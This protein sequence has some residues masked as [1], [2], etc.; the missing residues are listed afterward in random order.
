M[1]KLI[2]NADDFG[3][4]PLFN[5]MILELIEEEAVTSTS[6]MVDEIDFEQKEQ[7]KK[8]IQLAKKHHLSIGLHVYF[9]STNFKK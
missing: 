2:I 6:V 3:F 4:R 5:K 1:I 7:V 9:K 8:L